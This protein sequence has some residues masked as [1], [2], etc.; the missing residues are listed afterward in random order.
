[1]RVASLV[2][3]L[4]TRKTPY[5]VHFGVT[6]RCNLTCRMCG[7]WKMGDRRTEVTT[8]QVRAIAANLRE[9]GTGVV[10][11]G[12][13]EPLL[14]DDLPQI[15]RAFFEQGIEV[16][17]LTNGYTRTS[18]ADRNV[19]FLDEVCD[20]GLRHVSISLDTTDPRRFGEICEKDDVWPVA[21]Q[22]V[23]RFSRLLAQRGGMGNLNC[24]VS[25]ANLRELPTLVDM[26]ERL[27]F[28][29]SFIPIEVHEYGGKQLERERAEG[30][31]FAPS[32]HA[33]LDEMYARLIEMKRQGRP[34]FSSTPFLEASL[35]CLKGEPVDWTCYAGSLYFS[36]S[37][38][39]RFSVCHRFSGT[40]QTRQE[41]FVYEPHF[42]RQFR[43]P[44][45]ADQCA[46]TSRP[47]RACLRPCWAEVAMTFCNPRSF[48]EMVSI[49][50]HHPG[51]RDLS[52]FDEIV[53]T[54]APAGDAPREPA[55]DAGVG[56]DAG[57]AA[58][59]GADAGV[60]AGVGAD[61]GVAEPERA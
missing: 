60:A 44:V 3:A 52:S 11:L 20:T 18:A 25:R 48:W 27:G 38:E 50:L 58:G 6:H 61:A 34:I 54:F 45:F 32:D 7:I 39:G 29:I 9:L 2:R 40:G 56:A 15:I 41:Y 33:E 57:V 49:Q 30:M 17:L 35:A 16:R 28:W 53:R 19:R 13:G 55:A 42:P 8:E 21:V 31:F 26:A 46:R 23:Q 10:S 4:A 43:D 47:C 14:R 1:M 12:G 51:P 37:P 22:T 59:V 36:I 5:Y 24:V